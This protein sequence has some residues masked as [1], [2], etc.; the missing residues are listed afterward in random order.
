MK[1]TLQNAGPVLFADLNVVGAAVKI[2]LAGGHK[3]T[4]PEMKRAS[5]ASYHLWKSKGDAIT[6]LVVNF[7][8]VPEIVGE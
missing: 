2:I 8:A 5:G 7:E 1:I 6:A 4:E 3:L